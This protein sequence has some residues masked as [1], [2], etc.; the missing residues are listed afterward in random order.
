MNCSL[1][2]LYR[3]FFL[4]IDSLPVKKRAANPVFCTV[5][6]VL[7]VI[8][9][10]FPSDVMAWGSSEPQNVPCRVDS[11]SRPLLTSTASNSHSLWWG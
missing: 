2:D 8:R 9:R 5:L 10:V 7:K 3:I 6:S 1:I 11:E 4:S